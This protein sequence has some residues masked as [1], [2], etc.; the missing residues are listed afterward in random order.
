MAD[1]VRAFAEDAEDI[2]QKIK[3]FVNDVYRR[4]P[5]PVVVTKEATDNKTIT[6]DGV[7]YNYRISQNI[8]WFKLDP[9]IETYGSQIRRNLKLL[10]PRDIHNDWISED[11]LMDALHIFESDKAFK[12]YE[13]ITEACNGNDIVD[14]PW[15]ID[16]LAPIS[17]VIDGDKSDSSRYLFKTKD[18]RNHQVKVV[19]VI[20]ESAENRRACPADECR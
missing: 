19:Y 20:D 3:D 15:S 4:L 6:V 8:R 13:K 7:E 11:G 14:K 1:F 9:F 16:D 18:I 17:F 2:L 12:I 5:S 10:D